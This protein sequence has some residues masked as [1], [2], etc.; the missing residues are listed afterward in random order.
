MRTC[1]GSQCVH[2]VAR[3]TNA[4]VEVA[5]IVIIVASASRTSCIHAMHAQVDPPSPEALTPEQERLRVQQIED[6]LNVLYSQQAKC[7]ASAC[8]DG[9]DLCVCVCVCMCVCVS[10]FVCACVYYAA[11]YGT[12]GRSVA[13]SLDRSIAR[14]LGHSAMEYDHLRI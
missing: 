9:E 6:Q 7:L 3:S 13:R 1:R 11:N 10:M 12:L 8:M 5:R 4:R 14:S 2:A